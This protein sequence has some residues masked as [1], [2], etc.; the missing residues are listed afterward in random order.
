MEG[1]TLKAV[2]V[3][4]PALLICV[5]EGDPQPTVTWLK[6]CIPVDFSDDRLHVLPSGELY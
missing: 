2:E 1:P 6:D 3:G 4:R 5:T